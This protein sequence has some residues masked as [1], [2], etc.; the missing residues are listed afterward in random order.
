MAMAMAMAT[1]MV[2]V[3]WDASLPTTPGSIFSRNRSSAPTTATS[4]VVSLQDFSSM[5]IEDVDGVT[6]TCVNT[7]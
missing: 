2:V 7:H 1:M 4:V 5:E 6:T 3:A